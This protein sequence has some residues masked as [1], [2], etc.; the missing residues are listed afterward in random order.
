VPGW[1]VVAGQLLLGAGLLS[2]VA[3]FLLREYEHRRQR[4]R[5]LRGLLRLLMTEIRINARELRQL[6]PRLEWL[7]VYPGMVTSTNAWDK[8]ATRLAQL[9]RS[10]E[11]FATVAAYYYS[12]K[13]MNEMR[14]LGQSRQL[15]IEESMRSAVAIAVKNGDN[16]LTALKDELRE[17]GSGSSLVHT[18]FLPHRVFCKSPHEEISARYARA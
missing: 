3:A 15:N 4:I 10:D 14:Q 17:A 13:Q 9:M 8:S 18:A 2:A 6:D 5:E 11:R 12:I 16:A 7:T 1:L